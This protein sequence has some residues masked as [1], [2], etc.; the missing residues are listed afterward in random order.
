MTDKD[1]AT[2]GDG[3]V[4]PELSDD[5]A[6]PAEP[7][8]FSLT[9]PPPFFA[10]RANYDPRYTSQKDSHMPNM[11]T[12]KQPWGPADTSS[13]K[14]QRTS[15]GP[16]ETTLDI[17]LADFGLPSCGE[18]RLRLGANQGDRERALQYPL[19]G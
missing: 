19:L 6:T 1:V 16:G 9:P 2:L 17:N 3:D 8:D 15:R 12:P 18:R 11:P 14:E 5:E 4:L 10:I 13:N 7:G